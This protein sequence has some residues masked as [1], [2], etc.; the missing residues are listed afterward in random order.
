MTSFLVVDKDKSLERLLE[1]LRK[2]TSKKVIRVTSY[3]DAIEQAMHQVPSAIFVDENVP[4]GADISH[5]IK[6]IPELRE[7]HSIHFVRDLD[8]VNLSNKMVNQWYFKETYAPETVVRSVKH[9]L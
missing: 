8:Y 1:K 4:F 6:K 9:L 2:S 7:V 5:S 3:G